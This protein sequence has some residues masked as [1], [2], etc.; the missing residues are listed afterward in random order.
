MEDNV[1]H[2]G[3][4]MVIC[5]QVRDKIPAEAGKRGRNGGRFTPERGNGKNP[6]EAKVAGTF[7]DKVAFFY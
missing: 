2:P 1:L 3:R 5:H 6:A 4:L 7:L